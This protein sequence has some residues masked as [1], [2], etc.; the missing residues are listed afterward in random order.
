MIVPQQ[1]VPLH[2]MVLL[3]Y[4]TPVLLIASRLFLVSNC[5][6]DL[7]VCVHIDVYISD[8]AQPVKDLC[9]IN[10]MSTI[11]KSINQS[12]KCYLQVQVD[13]YNNGM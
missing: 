4:R 12:I 11:A 6:D 8:S 2:S 9:L 13:L 1:S 7:Y 10:Y 3:N 5:D